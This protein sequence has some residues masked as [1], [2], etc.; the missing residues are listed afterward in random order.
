[1]YHKS[2]LG[3]LLELVLCK[4]CRRWETAAYI[5]WK[6]CER[7]YNESSS[8]RPSYRLFGGDEWHNFQVYANWLKK[9]LYS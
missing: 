8:R 5:S 9:L 7:C 2:V 3:V 4:I 6:V 1:M